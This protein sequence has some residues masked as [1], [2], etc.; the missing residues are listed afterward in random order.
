MK[1]IGI[2][3]II[4]DVNWEFD[5]DNFRRMFEEKTATLIHQKVTS[6]TARDLHRI[7]NEC[8]KASY[9]IGFNSTT[10]EIKS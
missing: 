3:Q 2:M 1:Q 8:L 10:K 5:V 6:K 4:T 9:H 7:A